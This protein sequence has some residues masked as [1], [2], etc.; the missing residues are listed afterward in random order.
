ML[1]TS[2]GWRL[3]K[4][5]ARLH[6]YRVWQEHLLWFL[7]SGP[8]L[9]CMHTWVWALCKGQHM[10]LYDI[11]NSCGVGTHPSL[12]YKVCHRLAWGAQA[13]RIVSCFVDT[14]VWVMWWDLCGGSFPSDTCGIS[15]SQSWSACV[16]WQVKLPSYVR[17]NY[18]QLRYYLPQATMEELS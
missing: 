4:M 13:N 16:L 7:H 10:C 12:P 1:L 6:K 11:D 8:G 3:G 15:P 5:G 9:L 14:A 17:C 18:L 2:G